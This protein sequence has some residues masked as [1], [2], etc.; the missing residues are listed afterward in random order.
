MIEPDMAT[1]LVFV[2]TDAMLP[3]GHE[4]MQKCLEVAVNAD[5]SF[6]RI[7]VDSDQST[8]DM[9][10]LVSSEAEERPVDV[11]AFEAALTEVCAALAEDV[12]RNGEGVQ[13]VIRATVSGAPTA[14]LAHAV[15]KAVVNSPLVKTAVAGNDPN[16]GRVLCAIGDCLGSGGEATP[17]EVAAASSSCVVTMGGTTVFERGEFAL[18][19]KKEVE[20][21]RYLSDAEIAVVAEEGGHGSSLGFPPH[22]RVVDIGID[23]GA[24]T[25]GTVVFGSDLTHGYVSENADYRS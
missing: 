19:P 11:A 23:L 21:V 20:L 22:E 5:G 24:G 17:A 25:E 3:G 8:S 15:A 2:L 4:A 9:V 14:A 13:H 1:M 16:V 12:V 7:S 18:D 10:L 6:N